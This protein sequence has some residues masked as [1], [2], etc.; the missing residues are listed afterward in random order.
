MVLAQ[1]GGYNVESNSDWDWL[2]H[3][4]ALWCEILPFNRLD[5]DFYL[6]QKWITSCR[7]SKTNV[8]QGF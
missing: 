4:V 2:V 8:V 5:S 7:G 3:L 1:E 6:W